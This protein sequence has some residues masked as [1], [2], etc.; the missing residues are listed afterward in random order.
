MEPFIP[1]F[2]ALGIGLVVLHDHIDVALYDLKQEIDAFELRIAEDLI[3]KYELNTT[4][5][6][7]QNHVDRVEEKTIK[8]EEDCKQKSCRI[9]T[10]Q[11]KK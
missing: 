2:L 1:L 4:L 9:V 10:E 7:M 8:I 5:L 3:S 11:C 6:R